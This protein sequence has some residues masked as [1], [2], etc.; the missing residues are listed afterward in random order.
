M[1]TTVIG[2]SGF[3][4]AMKAMRMPYKSTASD[5]HVCTY[6]YCEDCDNCPS[7]EYAEDGFFI[8][9]K[10][11][12]ALSGE[13]EQDA[14]FCI[15]PKDHALCMKLVKAGPEHRKHIRQIV[16]WFEIDAPLY[17]WSEFDTYHAGI[18]KE[19]ESTM[20]TLKKGEIMPSDFDFDEWTNEDGWLKLEVV[21][22]LEFIEQNRKA[23]SKRALKQLLPCGYRQKRVVMASY[24]ALSKIYR[25]RH[26]H[27]LKE[28]HQFCDVLKTLPYS[29]FI[30]GEDIEKG[31]DVQKD[32]DNAI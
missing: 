12:K 4:P 23:A 1:K 2:V 21:R 22:F 7:A 17:F 32:G 30:V 9:C 3:E 20:H 18:D 19:S 24:E 6:E 25:E 5:S 16:A 27:E 31:E 15:G 13:L 8:G 28:W 14:S 29:E 11:A 26:N 10:L